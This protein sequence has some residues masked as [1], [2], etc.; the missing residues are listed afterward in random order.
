MEQRLIDSISEKLRHLKRYSSEADMRQ[1]LRIC[2]DDA[3]A[4]AKWLVEMGNTRMLNTTGKGEKCR[5]FLMKEVHLIS[6]I[7]Y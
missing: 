2:S 7:A 1:A 4:A 6:F 3:T 5:I